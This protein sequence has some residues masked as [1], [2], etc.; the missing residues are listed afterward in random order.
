MQ[1][2]ST[3]YLLTG[4]NMGD[5]WARLEQAATLIGDCCGRIVQRSPVYE[6][7]AWG[8]TDQAAFL[9]QALELQTRYSAD[10]LM[11]QLLQLE[12]GMG[13]IRAE[14]YGPRTIDI[15]ILLFD[16]LVQSTQ[17]LTIPH[18][19]MHK[20]R[21]ALQP[22]AAIAPAARH[23]ALQKSIAALLAECPDGL[24]VREAAGS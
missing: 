15:N 8:N 19:E 24:P 21:F 20:R 13:R 23:P 18:P 2:Y 5:R 6:T 16:D 4:S 1:Y 10:A 22:L 12:E 11:Q 17:L 14:R 7:A 9:N 3:A